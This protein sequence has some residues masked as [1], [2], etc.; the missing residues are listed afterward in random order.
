MNLAD[1][2]FETWKDNEVD[3]ICDGCL[4]PEMSHVHD[5]DGAPCREQDCE[6][7]NYYRK[8]NLR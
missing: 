8:E 2:F 1:L 3:R 5:R 7:D 4:H 6:C